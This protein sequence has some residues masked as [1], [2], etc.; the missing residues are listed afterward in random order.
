MIATCTSVGAETAKDILILSPSRTTEG[1]RAKPVAL[2]GRAQETAAGID[3][4]TANS[5]IARLIVIAT[6][7][8]SGFYSGLD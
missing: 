6:T 2:G 8:C 5:I 4:R 1:F 3:T 7:S